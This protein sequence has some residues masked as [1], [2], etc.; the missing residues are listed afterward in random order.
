VSQSNGSGK[1][2]PK[3]QKRLW[4]PAFA[5]MTAGESPRLELSGTGF[6]GMTNSRCFAKLNF[7]LILPAEVADR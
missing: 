1:L 5:G 7:F 2:F 3:V 4:I 6:A